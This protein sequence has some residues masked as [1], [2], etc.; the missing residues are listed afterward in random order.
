[1]STIS[2]RSRIDAHNY[3]TTYKVH[4][5]CRLASAVRSSRFSM[6]AISVPC[7]Q[8]KLKIPNPRVPSSVQDILAVTVQCPREPERHSA[9]T[10]ELSPHTCNLS[11]ECVP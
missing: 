3:I 10:S 1:M 7:F 8:Q 9:H 11:V 5:V 4:E 2:R 6:R